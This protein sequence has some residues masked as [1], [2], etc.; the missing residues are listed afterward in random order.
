MG[1]C[2]QD[3]L[4]CAAGDCICTCNRC[5]VAR[6]ETRNEMNAKLAAAEA[7]ADKAEAQLRSRDAESA[8][9]YAGARPL[10]E[11][12][13]AVMDMRAELAR[14]TK[15]AESRRP[16]IGVPLLD[17]APCTTV[18]TADIDALVARAA[19]LEANNARM[20]EA[21]ESAADDGHREMCVTM[22]L[23]R[24]CTCHQ[25]AT[26]KAL[27]WECSGCDGEGAIA[28]VEGHGRHDCSVCDASGRKALGREL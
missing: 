9:S 1:H 17:S 27:G 25:A 2:E 26:L 21:L 10:D 15:E 11:T 5:Y 22:R 23:Y 14:V 3:R 12:V 13:K 20:R 8:L 6:F 18:K 28:A 4:W 19:E 7:R 24:G 16:A